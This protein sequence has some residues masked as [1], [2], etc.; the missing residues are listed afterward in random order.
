[1]PFVVVHL[2]EGRSVEQKR[3]LARAITDAMVQLADASPEALHV[4]IQEYPRESWARGGV[5]AADLEGHVEPADRPPAVWRLDHVLLEVEDLERAEAFYVGTLGF[6]VRKRDTHRDG[7]P[8]VVTEQGLG[9]TTGGG[10]AGT[11][12]HL[13]FRTRNVAALAEKLRSE[14]VEIVDGPSPTAYG[15]SLYVRDPDGN[16][17]E[18]FGLR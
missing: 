17:V 10:G 12:E 9:L 16:K 15:I 2:W 4:A 1:M 8:L 5:L 18:L 7:R 3:L 6:S 11:V 13:A 14:G